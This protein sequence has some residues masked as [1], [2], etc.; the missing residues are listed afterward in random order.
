M[1]PQVRELAAASVNYAKQAGGKPGS[2]NKDLVHRI[3]KIGSSGKHKQNCERDLQFAVAS[4]AKALR[5]EVV[6]GF[7]RLWDPASNAIVV[8][9]LAFLDPVSLASALFIRGPHVFRYCFFGGL[10]EA[11][12]SAYWETTAARC[13]WFKRSYAAKWD[14]PALRRLA[15]VSL[16][17]DDVNNYRNT[18]AG[19]ISIISWTSDLSRGN[20][21]FLRYF[22]LS[23]YSEYTACQHTFS[24][25]MDT[26]FPNVQA[27][28]STY[29]P[30]ICGCVLGPLIS[31]CRRWCFRAC[32]SSATPQQGT[33]FNS[34]GIISCSVPC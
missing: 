27:L 15:P 19:N 12:V 22:L 13:E 18:E 33:T 10:D 4:F 21:P 5:T 6:E 23:L 34:K 28:L 1:Y 31:C 30:L 2:G 25:L 20:S 3:S 8:S 9:K 24:D 29:Y 17:G 26:W 32:R 16:H 14:G 7:C 11:Q